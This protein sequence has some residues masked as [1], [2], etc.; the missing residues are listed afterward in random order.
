MESEG[1]P[2]EQRVLGTLPE[3]SGRGLG[4]VAEIWGDLRLPAL[5]GVKPGRA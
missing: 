2:G 3:G 4:V 5:G 1:R